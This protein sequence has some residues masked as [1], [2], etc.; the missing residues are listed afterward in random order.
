MSLNTID[1]IIV[2][3]YLLLTIFIGL[4]LKKRAGKDMDSYLLGGRKLPWY[5]L[6]LSNASG[7][8]DI[9]GTMWLLSLSLSLSLREASGR[10]LA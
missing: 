4:F 5:F 2:V 9:S 6:G 10:F 1:V 8:F 3:L 7:M